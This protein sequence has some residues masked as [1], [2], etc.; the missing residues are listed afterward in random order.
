ML[1]TAY[2]NR[3]KSVVAENRQRKAHLSKGATIGTISGQLPEVKARLLNEQRE[4]SSKAQFGSVDLI[5]AVNGASLSGSQ[6]G[7]HPSFAH[8]KGTD[9]TENHW[10]VS[11]FIDIKG[12]TNLFKDYDLQE[13]YMITNTIQAAEIYTVIALGGHVQRLQG[14]GILAY[15]GGRG[16]DKSEAARMALIA[17]SLISYFV[18]ND[19][20]DLF[21]K[22]GIEEISTRIG[23]DFG[24]DAD[25]LWANFGVDH[26]SELT[27]LSLHTSLASKMQSN[28]KPNGVVAGDNIRE[29]AP[30]YREFFSII[31]EP[32]RYI[33][34]DPAAKFNYTQWAFEWFKF[35]KK[36]P[37]ILVNTDET[38]SMIKTGAPAVLQQQPSATPDISGLAA[39][40]ATNR[41]YY[42]DS[43]KI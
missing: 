31:S 34:R 38:L 21:L 13:I 40:A 25:V 42:D 20:K 1:Y 43:R 39:M 12:S 30:Q 8:L 36:Q 33:F 2:T 17:C 10:I 22:D 19:L 18:K 15:F 35:L 26:L 29:L 37:F 5:A 9:K 41:P 16:I 4:F 28:A 14:D 7:V 32:E 23:I 11:V 27:T 6:L 24:N 3:I